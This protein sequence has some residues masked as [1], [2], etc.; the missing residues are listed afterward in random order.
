MPTCA[1]GDS[2]DSRARTC[3]HCGRTADAGQPRMLVSEQPLPRSRKTRLACE[4]SNWSSRDDFDPSDVYGRPDSVSVRAAPV[5][6]KQGG[7]VV[8]TNRRIGTTRIR[9]DLVPNSGGNRARYVVRVV[10]PGREAAPQLVSGAFVPARPFRATE[11][12]PKG[13]PAREAFN[14]LVGTLRR[15]GWVETRQG[16]AWYDKEFARTQD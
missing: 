1:C 11:L 7:P 15:M 16:P 3:P 12:P 13:N 8:P 2:Y 5:P 10:Q 9:I 14:A 6:S 4:G